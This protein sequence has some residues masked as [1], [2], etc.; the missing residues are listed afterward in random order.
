ME[1][2]RTYLINAFSAVGSREHYFRFGRHSGTICQ[3]YRADHV[4]L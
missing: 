2:L 1:K 3:V 4:S